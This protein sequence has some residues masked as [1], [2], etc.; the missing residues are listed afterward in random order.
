MI[1]I[2]Y[3]TISGEEHE[4]LDK[5]DAERRAHMERLHRPG[6][7]E[8]LPPDVQAKVD[9]MMDAIST[10]LCDEG[11]GKEPRPWRSEQHAADTFGDNND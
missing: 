10:V 5:L 1:D 4:R 9:E 3:A 2:F 6:P 11:F 7:G 8:K